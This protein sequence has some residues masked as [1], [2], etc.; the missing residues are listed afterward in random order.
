MSPS[1]KRRLAP[2]PLAPPPH[3]SRLLFPLLDLPPELL[4]HIFSFVDRPGVF[5]LTQAN[6]HFYDLVEG[7][8]DRLRKVRRHIIIADFSSKLYVSFNDNAHF[9]FHQKRLW[10]PYEYKSQRCLIGKSEP[11]T[12]VFRL[13][14]EAFNSGVLSLCRFVLRH[15][16]LRH[17]SSNLPLECLNSLISSW[18]FPITHFNSWEE[19]KPENQMLF[20]EVLS[21]LPALKGLSLRGKRSRVSRTFY[22]HRVIQG[23]DQ[24]L[25]YDLHNSDI[26]QDVD[27]QILFSSKWPIFYLGMA[28]TRVSLQ[29]V[30]EF[31]LQWAKGERNPEMY[32]FGLD[33]SSLSYDEVHDL[34]TIVDSLPVTVQQH[35]KDNKKKHL[36]RRDGSFLLIK[37]CRVSKC[38]GIY[39]SRNQNKCIW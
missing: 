1:L 26:G 6:R 33:E 7:H 17:F 14:S 16:D 12:T 31:L 23:L 27:G 8:I 10:T 35:P 34:Y 21:R 32:L 25:T 20:L 22:E 37:Y 39:S 19:L 3:R 24:L 28:R 30:N 13:T 36:F 15:C 2:S 38:V 11:F 9:D 18:T 4:C 5:K 29:E